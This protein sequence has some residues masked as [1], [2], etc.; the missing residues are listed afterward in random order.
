[1][2]SSPDTLQVLLTG[3]AKVMNMTNHTGLWDAVL[4]WYSP[5][6]THWI[7]LYSLENGLRIH[8]FSPTRPCQGSCILSKISWTIWLLYCDRLHLHFCTTNIFG[9]FL[10]VMAKFEQI[11]L[12]WKR[13]LT[14]L[15]KMCMNMSSMPGRFDRKTW[16]PSTQELKES[17]HIFDLILGESTAEVRPHACKLCPSKNGI[18]RVS[19][20]TWR[21]VSE[22][23]DWN[24]C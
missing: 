17:D 14:P 4:T 7:C 15:G 3:F 21:S 8:V 11:K 5:S 13:L 22:S 12:W 24:Y 1:M 20:G 9:C 2:L 6:D 19:F 10:S 16:L 18:L 23:V